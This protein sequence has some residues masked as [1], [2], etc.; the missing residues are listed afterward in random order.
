MLIPDFYT[1]QEPIVDKQPS[2]HVKEAG[3]RF[4]TNDSASTSTF[5]VLVRDPWQH[6]PALTQSVVPDVTELTCFGVRVSS[7]PFPS[8]GVAEVL[9]SAAWSLLQEIVEEED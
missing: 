1:I 3:P 2:Y 9:S 5:I 4:A 8:F 6:E 7:E